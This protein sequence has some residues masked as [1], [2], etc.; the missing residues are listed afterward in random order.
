MFES[1]HQLFNED[2]NNLYLTIRVIDEDREKLFDYLTSS[3]ILSLFE[4]KGKNLNSEITEKYNFNTIY[5]CSSFYKNP[6]IDN[7]FM[8]E[9][10]AKQDKVLFPYLSKDI[11]N[12]NQFMFKII[13]EHQ[14][15]TDWRE[16]PVE[17]LFTHIRKFGSFEKYVENLK[18]ENKLSSILIE[19]PSGKKYKI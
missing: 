15:T 19:K 3:E 4:N 14:A 9:E 2:I 11:A 10:M 18:L 1:F 8:I 7:K 6:I 12:D 5:S 17:E 16:S 13:V